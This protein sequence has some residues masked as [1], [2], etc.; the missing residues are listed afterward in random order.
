MADSSGRASNP[1]ARAGRMRASAVTVLGGML[2][3]TA[4]ASE[5]RL[6]PFSLSDELGLHSQ[7]RV[8]LEDQV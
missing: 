7:N 6:S 5:A 2:V 8:N 4:V 1:L 3:P